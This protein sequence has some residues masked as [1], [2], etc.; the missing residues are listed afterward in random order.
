MHKIDS[1]N[2]GENGEWVAGNPLTGVQPTAATAAWFNAI[3]EEFTHYI[4]SR[5]IVLS[6]SNNHQLT[7]AIEQHLNAFVTKAFNSYTPPSSGGTAYTHPSSHPASMILENAS[8]RFVTDALISTWNSKANG[9]H[10][11]AASDINQDASH[12]FVTDAERLAW[13]QAASSV[14]WDSGWFSVGLGQTYTKTHNLGEVPLSARLLLKSTAGK[15]VVG[16]SMIFN[17]VNSGFFGTTIEDLTT[18]QIK[19]ATGNQA[20]WH[21]AAGTGSNFSAGFARIIV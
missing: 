2:A 17:S 6:K 11:H 13:N 7:A 4:E 18:T 9:S 15:V 8:K 19:I 5:G 1:T 14:K 3:Q 20:L 10:S 12:R 21:S 16:N